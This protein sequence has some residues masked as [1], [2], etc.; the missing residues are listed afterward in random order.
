MSKTPPTLPEE[1]SALEVPPG[2]ERV[3]TLGT[4]TLTV[5][6]DQGEWLVSREYE[7]MNRAPGP[8]PYPTE[9]VVRFVAQSTATDRVQIEPVLAP[10]PIVARPEMPVWVLAGDETR[11]FVSTALWVRLDVGADGVTLDELPTVMLKDTWFGQSTRVGELC[12]ASR[13]A[14][15]VRMTDALLSAFRA[16]TVIRIENR[17]DEHMQ[18][19]RVKIPAPHLGLWVSKQGQFFTQEVHVVHSEGGTGEAKVR[20][21]PPEAGD[22]KLV[23]AARTTPGRGGVFGALGGLLG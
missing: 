15:R 14:A 3:R 22:A 1:W 21:L 13:T 9:D 12:Y 17:S 19:Q 6:R 20:S 23:R 10:R 16:I 8:L 2:E 11:V 5:S 18:V 7:G 4:L